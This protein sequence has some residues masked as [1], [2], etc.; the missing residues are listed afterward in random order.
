MR[1]TLLTRGAFCVTGHRL[2]RGGLH[3][4]N[5]RHV[6]SQVE[7]S[8]GSKLGQPDRPFNVKL[9]IVHFDGA[10]DFGPIVITDLKCRARSV[11]SPVLRETKLVKPRAYGTAFE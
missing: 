9:R 11:L 1:G 7:T 8:V 4:C 6:P 10:A 2:A 5:P 3:G